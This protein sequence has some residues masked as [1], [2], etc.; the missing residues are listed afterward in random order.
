MRR[1]HPR[2]L[3]LCL[4]VA[5][6][7]TLHAQ[8]PQPNPAG[9]GSQP[10]LDQVLGRLAAAEARI[11]ELER[12]LAV[13]NGQVSDSANASAAA[14]T[15][16][17]T[18][19]K[20]NPAPAA[21]SP[22][23]AL[24][25]ASASDSSA[26]QASDP[27]EHVVELPGGG[28]TLKIRGFFDFDF[29]VGSDANPLVFPLGIAP[30]N[31]FQMGEFDLM[32]SS[33]LSDKLSFMSEIV[34]SSDV[35]NTM[36]IDIERF[37]LQYSPSKYFEAGFGRYHTSIGYY[38]TA[39]HHGTWFQTATGR[40]FMYFFEDGGGILPVHSTGVTLTG[41]VPG[42]DSLGLHWV[43]ELSNGRASNNAAEAAQSFSTDKNHKA[44]NLAGYIAP[45]WLNGFQAGA[46][47][48]RDRM[49]PPG[50]KPVDQTIASVYGVFI[51]PT[52]E[53]MNEGVLLRN[54]VENGGRTF[55]TPLA[56]TQLS[57]KFGA[58]RPYFRYQYVNSPGDDPVNA[59][60]GLYM[61]P[62]A[63][64]RWDFSEYA[65]FKLQYNR[66]DQRSAKPANGLQTQLAFTF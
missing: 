34:F 46:S 41:L 37:L 62:S 5:V 60:R 66:L 8:E 50:S 43:A 40:P 13:Q 44:Y 2:V 16:F 58:W 31:G 23:P 64:L 45:Q 48:Y 61:G 17:A 25:P 33:R 39:F 7:V 35:T 6:A 18:E 29:G 54:R 32:T 15:G 42:T 55:D 21:P 30:H 53:F 56:Y 36:G 49:F 27:H 10:T 38:N 51:T 63:G 9:G 47:L 19:S 12:R 20:P 28:P 3:I 59:Y 14:A 52:W 65:A 24:V 57:R 22:A 4:V 11:Q 26:E 1:L